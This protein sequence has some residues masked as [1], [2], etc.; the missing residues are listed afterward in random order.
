MVTIN[1]NTL[2]DGSYN[3]NFE[4][5]EEQTKNVTSALD[6]AG[7]SI[8]EVGH[9]LGYGAYRKLNN[10]NY[11]DE[12]LLIS[13][14]ESRKNSDLS[15]FFIPGVGN[16]NDIKIIANYGVDII[17]IGININEYYKAQ[18]YVEYAKELGLKVCVNGMKSYAVKSYEFSKISQKID[19]WGTV[20]TIYLVD[21]AGCMTPNEV[22]GI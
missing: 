17:R 1:E 22:S 10:D 11:K 12:K 7:F 14:I 21:S 9:G 20:D 5:T 19:S 18:K 15:I 4:V 16:K 2:R 13:A 6:K 8:I 3:L